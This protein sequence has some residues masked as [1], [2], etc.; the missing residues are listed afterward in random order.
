MLSIISILLWIQFIKF[1]TLIDQVAPLIQIMFKIISEIKVF[2]L[3]FF[4]LL[5]AYG[6]SFYFIGRNQIEFDGIE[7]YNYP[8]YSE[9][10]LWSLNHVLNIA[11]G[12]FNYPDYS[13]GENPTQQG[14][15]WVLY[16]SAILMLTLN[17]L[18]ML[19]AIMMDIFQKNHET[20]VQEEKRTH[21]S[22]IIDNWMLKDL[23]LASDAKELN[24]GYKQTKQ[25]NHK[26]IITAF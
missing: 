8:E 3:I 10:L 1:M 14:I 24:F 25:K 4:V 12:E 6:N 18:N 19:I 9:H 20:K 2:S 22:F 17:L 26:Y 21:L 7:A 16:L 5:F 15:L 11:L 23:C 13:A